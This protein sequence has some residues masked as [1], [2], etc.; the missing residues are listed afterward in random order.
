MSKETIRKLVVGEPP[1]PMEVDYFNEVVDYLN[2]VIDLKAVGMSWRINR[3]IAELKIDRSEIAAIIGAAFVVDSTAAA[4]ATSIG[5]EVTA[6]TVNGIMATIGTTPLDAAPAPTI[7]TAL[8]SGIVY[9]EIALDWNFDEG[10][11]GEVSAVE[12][13]VAAT[14]P[15]ATFDKAIMSLATYTT[16][17][18][19]GVRVLKTLTQLTSGN[20]QLVV[21]Q[22]EYLLI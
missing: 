2:A 10:T 21:W 12:I 9:A 5:F 15:Q 6:G 22:G 20:K 8:A 18:Q 17:L 19:D 11:L 13:K 14:Q 1:T 4:T 7:T 16:E 3:S